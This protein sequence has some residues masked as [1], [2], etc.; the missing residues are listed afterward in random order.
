MLTEVT[1][2][3]QDTVSRRSCVS[4]K[5]SNLKLRE[6]ISNLPTPVTRRFVRYTLG[7]GVSVAVGLAPYLGRLDIPLFSSL[8]KL[9]PESI[10]DTAIPLSAA[11]MGVVAVVTEFYAGERLT[12]KAI[13][14]AFLR[15]LIV[16]GVAFI[17]L[18]TIHTLIVV[19]VPYL[20]GTKS[21]TFLVGFVRPHR[22]PCPEEVS[23]A[24]CIKRLTL[25]ESEIESFWGDKQVRIA[26]L[27]LVSAYLF[28]TGSFPV[29]VA[30]LLLRGEIRKRQ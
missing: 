9:I 29:L 18:L 12:R 11:L 3:K 15:M 4:R 23:D 8:L 21:A 5:D 27:S 22:P 2:F 19:K 10:Q 14:R 25:N 6:G 26:R 7:F 13:R 1:R 20:G 17:L 16:T 24:E 28:L 30:L